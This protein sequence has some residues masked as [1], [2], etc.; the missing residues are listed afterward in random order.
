MRFRTETLFGAAFVG[1]GLLGI[2]SH[3]LATDRALYSVEPECSYTLTSTGS[4]WVLTDTIYVPCADVAA[5]H[6]RLHALVNQQTGKI[7][8]AI[9]RTKAEL[10]E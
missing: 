1:G 4:G 9:R 2:L 10:G 6:R 8:D 3:A 7:S 5:R